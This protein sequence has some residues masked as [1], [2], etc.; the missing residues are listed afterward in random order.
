MV[1]RLENRKAAATGGVQKG[2]H[3]RAVK[4]L[5]H[6]GE[7]FPQIVPRHVPQIKLVDLKDRSNSIQRIGSSKIKTKPK[8]TLTTA[9]SRTWTFSAS[10]SRS[11]CQSQLLS[12]ATSAQT[13][14]TVPDTTM[15]VMLPVFICV[16]RQ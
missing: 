3:R 8:A 2:A 9:P 4:D 13:M 12:G 6:L 16:R 15:A 7:A 11:S 10:R 14:H 5:D 1:G